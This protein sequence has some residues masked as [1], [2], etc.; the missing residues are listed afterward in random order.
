MAK[1]SENSDPISPRSAV[2]ALSVVKSAASLRDSKKVDKEDLID[3]KFIDGLEGLAE[4]IRQELEAAYERAE[5]EHKLTGAEHLMQELL[6]KYSHINSK[7]IRLLQ[8]AKK[9]MQLQDVVSDLKVP[10]GLTERRKQLRESIAEKI[11]EVQST[12]LEATRI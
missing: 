12:A 6:D 11:T 9:L 10:N 8:M 7:P 4:N 3:L 2:Y 5:A 1:A